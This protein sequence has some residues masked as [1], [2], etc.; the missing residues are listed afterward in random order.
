MQ[1]GFADTNLDQ[2]QGMIMATCWMVWKGMYPETV[3]NG[4]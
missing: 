2:L 3:L 1:N 4:E